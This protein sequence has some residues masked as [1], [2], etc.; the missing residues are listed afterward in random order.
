MKFLAVLLL[1]VALV[2]ADDG[3]TK[4]SSNNVGDIVTVG[5]KAKADIS[6]KIDATIIGVLLKYLNAQGI[7]VNTGD[8]DYYPNYPNLPQIPNLPLP[9]N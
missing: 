8:D 5:V 1:A 6:N 7:F 3:P 4:I 9:R 2:S